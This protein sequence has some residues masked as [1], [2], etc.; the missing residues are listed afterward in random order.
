MLLMFGNHIKAQSDVDRLYDNL[1]YTNGVC[2]K[3]INVT[4]LSF[5]K[6]PISPSN[7]KDDEIRKIKQRIS[8]VPNSSVHFSYKEKEYYISIGN[9][10]DMTKYSEGDNIKIDIVFFEDI[11]QP[12]EYEKPFSFITSVTDPLSA[13]DGSSI[14]HPIKH[15]LVID[16]PFNLEETFHGWKDGYGYIFPPCNQFLKHIPVSYNGIEYDL[17]L[18]DD[19]KIKYISTSDKHFSVNGYKVG[20]EITKTLIIRGWGIFAKIDD[21]WY[22]GWMPKDMNHPEEEETGKIQCFFK[23]DFNK[24]LYEKEFE[25]DKSKLQPLYESC[26][27]L[28]DK[29]EYTQ[30]DKITRKNV[31]MVVEEMPQYKGG[32]G[33]FLKELANNVQYVYSENDNLQ[34][35]VQVQF[36]IDKKGQLIGARIYGK[37]SD[38][39][40]ELEKAVLKALC[41]TKDWQAGR[42]N[43]KPVNVLLTKA[44]NICPNH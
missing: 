21:E 17:G 18:S 27:S 7:D 13:Q 41:Q 28:E 2:K 5:G 1:Q 15:R 44:I 29:Q 33:V 30:Y 9:E 40:S 8:Y 11:K 19:E 14:L 4:Y 34:T 25:L 37:E 16:H 31:Y 42:Q 12:Y 24:P 32:E 36:V 23:F 38:A 26:K 3:T 39:L 10:C 43:G 22:A 20:D 35:R 6:N